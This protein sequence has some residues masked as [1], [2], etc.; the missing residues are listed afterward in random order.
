MKTK[1]IS[2]NE[3]RSIIKEILKEEIE[4]T[5]KSVNEAELKLGVKYTNKQGKEGFIQT[6]GSTNPKDWFWYDGKTKHP[7]TKVKKELKPSKNQKKTGFADYL[8]Q[9]GR[10]W[11]NLNMGGKSVNE[12]QYDR[13]TV[14]YFNPQYGGGVEGMGMDG[15]MNDFDSYSEAKEYAKKAYKEDPNYIYV[16]MDFYSRENRPIFTIGKQTPAFKNWLKNQ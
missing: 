8:K 1:K 12:I 15:M 6:G 16:V 7:Y 11:D 14:G 10:I 4:K 9:G 3:L 13:Y 2:I 5:N